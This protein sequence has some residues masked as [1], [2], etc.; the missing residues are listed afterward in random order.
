MLN[1]LTNKQKYLIKGVL[2]LAVFGLLVVLAAITTSPVAAE[3]E[4][5]VCASGC[6]FT[7]VQAAINA[8]ASEDVIK[9]AAGEYNTTATINKNLTLRGG[10]NADFSQWDPELYPTKLNANNAGRVIYASGTITLSLEGLDMLNG[11]ASNSGAGVYAENVNLKVSDSIIENNRVNPNFN[12]NYGVGLYLSGGSLY[13][14]DT[15]VQGNQPN[16]GGDYSHDGGGLYANASVLEIYDSQF[17]NN[18]AAFEGDSCGTGGGIRLENCT[19]LLQRVTFSNNAATNCNNGGGGLW[20]R[21]GSLSLLDSTFEGNTNSG[22]VVNTAGALIDGNTFTGNTGNGLVV[23]SWGDPVVNITVTQNLMQNN[24]GYGMIV[25]VRAASLVVDG[26]DFIGNANS[27]LKL[28]A[29]SDTGTVTAVIMRNN[30]F[31]DN[32]TTS[33]GGG[34]HLTGAVDV[35]FNRFLGNHANGKGG[36]VYQ[37]EY[38]SDGTSYSCKDNAIAVYD[39]NLFR[40]NSAAEGGGLY[41]IP[42]FSDNLNITYRNTV[43]LNNTVTGTGSAIYF[44]RYRNTPVTF[45]HLTVANNTG[46]DGAMIYQMMGNTFFTNTIMYSGTIGIK[47]HADYITLDHVLRYDVIT[48]TLNAGTWGLTDL[49]PITGPPA[50]TAD[51]YHLTAA[52]AAVDAG[53]DMGVISDIDE[54]PRPLGAAPDLGADES[55]Y[56]SSGNGVEANLLA[57]DPVWKIYFTGENQPPSTYLE[58]NYLIPY[59]YYAA[60]EAPVVS[61]Y[62]I[63]DNFPAELYLANVTSPENMTYSRFGNVLTWVSQQVLQ[64]DSWDWIG[65]TAR[66]QSVT[67]GQIITNTG[68]M[69]YNLANGQT[70]HIPLSVS[71]QVPTRPVFPPVLTTPEDGEVC[72]DESGLLTAKGV[73]GAGMTVKIYED[74]VLK[75]STV[76]EVNGEFSVEWTTGISEQ[77]PIDIYAIACDSGDTCSLP[78]RTVHLVYAENNWC[79]QR[80][81]WEG[82]VDGDH[83]NFYFRN[84]EGRFASNDFVIPGL[85]GFYNTKV[86]LYSCCDDQNTNPFR[87]KADGTVYVTPS[88]HNGRWWIFDITGGAHIVTVESQCGGIGS[89]NPLKT[90]HGEV[91]IDP[92]GFIFNSAKGGAYDSITGMYHPVEPLEGMTITAYAYIPEWDSWIQWP[93]HLYNNQINPQVT[94]NDGYFAFFTPP[95]KYYLEVTTANGYQ[96]WRS[97]VVEVVNEIVHVNIPLT[98]ASAQPATEQILLTSSGPQPSEVTIP[99]GGSITWVSALDVEASAQDLA[100]L[101]ENPLSQPRSNV[102]D[103]LLSVRGFDGGT[104]RPGEVYKRVFPTGGEYTYSDG[105]GHVGTIKVEQ[106]V[107]LP[108]LLK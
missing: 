67:G 6:D 59:A 18:T 96:T 85:Y 73:A 45:A 105:Y 46:G 55:P 39:G 50:F 14:Q 91:L 8:A 38:C 79:P 99:A 60:S 90:T 61:S 108:L 30:L 106:H 22:A 49:S 34:A 84:D 33:N 11:F 64:P 19:S 40:G 47:R 15:I 54:D 43:F 41:S 95:G 78:S 52:S 29:K 32:S 93:A 71:S 27:G 9:I 66:S 58:N 5:T 24:T 16:P 3:T 103:P 98:L 35:L 10:Y 104:L 92:D 102:L 94:G 51:G 89:T 44:Y 36:G 82:D 72:A 48:P 87:I 26:N 77:N 28:M 17:L 13:M 68:Q 20:T 57:S 62:T 76:A 56:T 42:Q 70:G 69:D 1:I 81:Y 2:G 75:G 7:N 101:N 25:P 21:I 97:P 80:S 31:Q 63:T 65:L 4:I 74:G 88:S 100:D 86:H 23:S 12:G 53:V 37:S 107:Y 83:Y